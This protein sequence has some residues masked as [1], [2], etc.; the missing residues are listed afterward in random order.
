MRKDNGDD[1]LT[2]HALLRPRAA[3]AWPAKARADQDSMPAEHTAHASGMGR[4]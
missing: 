4:R 2:D 3:A 1:T